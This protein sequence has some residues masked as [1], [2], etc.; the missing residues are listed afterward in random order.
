[1]TKKYSIAVDMG[2]TTVKIGLF[3][4]KDLMDVFTYSSNTEQD[5]CDLLTD[6]T[7]HIY[8]LMSTNNIQEKDV[9]G[10]G[11]AVPGIVD[12]KVKKIVS[13]N[14]K[15][16]AAEGFDLEGWFKEQ[17]GFNIVLENDANA[18]L[19]GEYSMGKLADAEYA[20][21]FMLGT[22]VGTAAM[23]NG[24]LLR[25]A[26]NQAGCLAGHISIA[27]NGRLCNCGAIGCV[28]AE[29]STWALPQILKESKM[30]T[31]SSLSHVEQAKI[32]DLVEHSHHDL[33]AKETL[34]DFIKKWGTG[35]INLIHAYDPEVI[36][37][38][39]GVMKAGDVVI[40]P[41]KAYVQ[42]HVW[43]TYGDVKFVISEEP[44]H[45]ALYGMN[46]HMHSIGE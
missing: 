16:K 27:V 36:L 10:I 40:D 37:L 34:E 2:G 30:Y 29:A 12:F 31:S 38:S 26:H 32:K 3:N 8:Q 28:E 44:E 15:Y 45:S 18:A 5:V 25:G 41:I 14:D 33:L 17:T 23:I 1:M 4:N 20:A 35:I 43:T 7:N 19:L 21:L 13:I 42:K 9:I 24:K 39:G 46:Y 6:L 11:L 22:G